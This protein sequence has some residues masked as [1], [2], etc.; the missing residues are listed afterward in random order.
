MSLSAIVLKFVP[1]IAI[2]EPA[3]PLDTFGEPM[4]SAR[5][6]GTGG[7]SSEVLFKGSVAVAE[8]K[9]PGV[10]ATGSCARKFVLPAPS[11]ATLMAPRKYWAS[12]RLVPWVV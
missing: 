5:L 8:M 1:E 11:V 9:N 7:D 12:L 3:E 2:V 10:T 6:A 4:P